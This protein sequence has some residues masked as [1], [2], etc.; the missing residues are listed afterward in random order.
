[1]SDIFLSYARA[2]RDKAAGLAGALER[3]GWSVW[4]DNDIPAGKTWAEVIQRALEDARCVVVLW[5]P[6]S[7]RSH[8][9][10]TEAREGL[11]RNVL[12]PVL[13]EALAMPLEFRSLQAADLAGWPEVAADEELAK[14][15][16][17]VAANLGP[18]KGAVAP[19]SSRRTSLPQRTLRPTGGALETAAAYPADF[20]HLIA[21]PKS[22]L[23][24]ERERGPRAL[25][26]SLYF[27]LFT[28]VVGFLLTLPLPTRSLPLDFLTSLAFVFV[29]AFVFAVAVYLAWR[30]VGARAPLR[31]FL[32]IHFYCAGVLKLIEKLCFLAFWGGLRAIGD[33]AW[34]ARVSD[35]TFCKGDGILAM[36][37]IAENE[38]ALPHYFAMTL[39]VGVVVTAWMIAIWGA[40]RELTGVS[41]LRSTFAAVAFVPLWA[42]A[43]A[44]VYLLSI[45]LASPQC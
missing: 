13:L 35:A 17:A 41:R 22:F 11:R 45:A 21:G 20:L 32:T 7:V 30:I 14:L 5:S 33:P 34:F 10:N 39:V 15:F 40:Y 6:A 42:V 3:R 25:S 36:K 28:F 38:R 1:M 31:D 23:A 16:A 12:V 43:M 44:I 37:L 18:S 2:D 9:V 8:W 29:T 26:R 19:A 24:G 4:W 27:L